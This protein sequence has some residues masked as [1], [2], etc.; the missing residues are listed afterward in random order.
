[1]KQQTQNSTV[2]FEPEV[3]SEHTK[4]TFTKVTNSKGTTIYGKIEKD[5]AEVGSISA[6]EAGNFLITS[7]KPVNKLTDEEVQEI[8]TKVPGWI[9]EASGD[10]P[11][12]TED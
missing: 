5:N 7:L 1:M 3:I 12:A 4:V 2:T 9:K 10:A 6:E 11:A 8:Y